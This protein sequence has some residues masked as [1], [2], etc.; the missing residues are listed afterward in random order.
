VTSERGRSSSA[1][2]SRCGWLSSPFE[3]IAGHRR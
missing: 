3:E 2:A 1:Q